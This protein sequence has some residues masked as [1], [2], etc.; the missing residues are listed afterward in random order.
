MIKTRWTERDGRFHF[1]PKFYK[2]VLQLVAASPVGVRIAK[3]PTISGQ[4]KSPIGTTPGG[5]PYHSNC[6]GTLY[7]LYGFD[8]QPSFRPPEHIDALLATM[9]PG[10]RHGGIALFANGEERTHVGFYLGVADGLDAI[11]HQTDTGGEFGIVPVDLV[12][13]QNPGDVV[14]YY[15][16]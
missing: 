11:V 3:L 13:A 2:D 5:E 10:K 6:V 7:F 8:S 4:G 16:F 9:K 12:L 15:R 1:S 14:E